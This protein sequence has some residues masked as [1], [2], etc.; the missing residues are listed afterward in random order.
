MK[1]IFYFIEDIFNKAKTCSAS[2]NCQQVIDI[3]TCKYSSPQNGGPRMAG[4]HP[5]DD[6][7]TAVC[8][9]LN[10]TSDDDFH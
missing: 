6:V 10:E 1:T 3:K 5:A 2:I 7:A 8:V 4:L 9:L